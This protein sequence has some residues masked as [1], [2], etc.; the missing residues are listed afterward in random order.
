MLWDPGGRVRLIDP[1]AHGGHRATGLAMPRLFGC[2]HLDRVSAGYQEVA[3][4]A[5][6]WSARAGIHRLF[7]LPVHAVLSGGGYGEQAVA[8]ARTAG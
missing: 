8:A 1:A 5:E 3:P 7:P 4:L 2:P 6:G